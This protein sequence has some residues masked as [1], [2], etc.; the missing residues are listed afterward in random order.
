MFQRAL[1]LSGIAALLLLTASTAGAQEKR[2]VAT[3]TVTTERGYGYVFYDDPLAAGQYG[4][5]TAILKVRRR[6]AHAILI[7]PRVQFVTE[8]LKSAES[9]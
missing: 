6:G 3:T 2:S 1:L 7:R 5:T 4:S 8:M 9:L